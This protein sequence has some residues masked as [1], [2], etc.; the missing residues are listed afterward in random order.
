[1]RVAA[2]GVRSDT[3]EAFAAI[4]TFL[5]SAGGS[6]SRTFWRRGK[7][8]SVLGSEQADAHRTRAQDCT[9]RQR[10]STVRT[11][12]PQRRPRRVPSRAP[13]SSLSSN[14]VPRPPHTRDVTLSV[15]RRNGEEL[16]RG[17]GAAEEP[18]ASPRKPP[19]F[20]HSAPGVRR[21]VPRDHA[22]SVRM[23]SE[24]RTTDVVRPRCRPPRRAEE[25]L[26]RVREPNRHVL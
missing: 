14:G 16:G 24:G 18:A 11:R 2:A 21:W 9:C 4:A 13:P 3:R 12:K 26:H 17:P 23:Q 5:L 8:T 20:A 10:R 19:D 25:G 1:M 6:E 7:G 15:R 22:I